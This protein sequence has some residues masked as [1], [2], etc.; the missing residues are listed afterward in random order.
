ML[1][2]CEQY[3]TKQDNLFQKKLQTEHKSRD[4]KCDAE[5]ER[6]KMFLFDLIA[7]F[8]QTMKNRENG[9]RKTTDHCA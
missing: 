9:K 7:F 5:S 1:Q 6:K 3:V 2:Q 8:E 4:Y